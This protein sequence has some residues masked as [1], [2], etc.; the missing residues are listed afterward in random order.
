MCFNR[1][2]LRGLHWVFL[3]EVVITT[4]EYSP[5]VLHIVINRGN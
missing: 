2:F 4:A 5:G 3:F 1:P